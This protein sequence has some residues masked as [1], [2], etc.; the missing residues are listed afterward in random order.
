MVPKRKH[1]GV[2]RIDRQTALIVFPHM[3][4][5]LV[6]NLGVFLFNSTELFSDGQTDSLPTRQNLG[7][8]PVHLKKAIFGVLHS[9]RIQLT[10]DLFGGFVLNLNSTPFGFFPSIQVDVLLGSAD[11]SWWV[12]GR[13]SRIMLWRRI[14]W[15]YVVIFGIAAINTND[16]KQEPYYSPSLSSHLLFIDHITLSLTTSIH[17][18]TRSNRSTFFLLGASDYIVTS[19]RE[20]IY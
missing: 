4:L 7:G 8:F 5:N 14:H 2:W 20:H 9:T 17:Y 6:F 11:L 19:G 15:C 12:C 3:Q 18:T 13:E 16:L 1:R 10:T